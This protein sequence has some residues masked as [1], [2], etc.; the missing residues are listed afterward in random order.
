MSRLTAAIFAAALVIASHFAVN[1]QATTGVL[2]GTVVDSAGS[3]VAGAKVTAK[4]EGTGIES[5]MTTSGFNFFI[6]WKMTCVEVS[7]RR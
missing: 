5:T 6:S 4:N 2:K 1:A 3:V 7:V